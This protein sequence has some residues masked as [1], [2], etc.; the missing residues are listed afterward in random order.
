MKQITNASELKDRVRQLEVLSEEKEELLKLHARGV[1]EH[2]KPVNILKKAI[3]GSSIMKG[4]FTK[5][6]ITGNLLQIGTS[7]LLKR[8]FTRPANRAHK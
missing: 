6:G 5:K 4:T 2:F 3:V 7:F 1:V 8:I